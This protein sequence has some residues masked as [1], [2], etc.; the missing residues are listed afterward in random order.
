MLFDSIKLWIA[1][2]IINIFSSQIK[3]NVELRSTFGDLIREVLLSE[4]VNSNLGEV[5]HS[6][7]LSEIANSLVILEDEQ[8]LMITLAQGNDVEDFIRGLKRLQLRNSRIIVTDSVD[9]VAV[10]D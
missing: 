8:T 2:L 10:L 1:G 5:V 7:V 4:P 6:V 3:T 9:K